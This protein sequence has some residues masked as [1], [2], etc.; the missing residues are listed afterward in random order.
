M[1]PL[2]VI[3]ITSAVLMLWSPIF[4]QSQ[5]EAE[6]KITD[7]AFTQVQIAAN[8]ST[9]CKKYKTRLQNAL[10]GISPNNYGALIAPCEE[11]MIHLIVTHK[12]SITYAK[13]FTSSK[14]EHL[15][16]ETNK[17]GQKIID[18]R[19]MP[20][21][22]RMQ[23]ILVLAKSTITAEAFQKYLSRLGL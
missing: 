2:T 12:E 7:E 19:S 10:S 5:Q 1:K 8:D 16:S 13:R 20:F 4:I 6:P 17:K 21:A 23:F 14:F 18:D 11:Y 15:S 3:G 9:S 22:D